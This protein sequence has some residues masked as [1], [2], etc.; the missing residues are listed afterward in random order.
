MTDKAI[1]GLDLELMNEAGG[2]SKSLGGGFRNDFS[3]DFRIV[4]SPTNP[5]GY[6]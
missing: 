3:S 4:H 2:F 5:Y 1:D 6:L